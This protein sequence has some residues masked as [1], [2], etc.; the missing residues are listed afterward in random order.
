M[1]GNGGEVNLT[2][3][4]AFKNTGSAATDMGNL[5]KDIF[6][7]EEEAIL[8]VPSIPGVNSHT[9]RKFIYA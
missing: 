9:L 8:T 5:A 6:E 1:V 3:S 2:G 4:G 7:N